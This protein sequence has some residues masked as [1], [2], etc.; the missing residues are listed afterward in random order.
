MNL[1]LRKPYKVIW[2]SI[3]IL[4]ILSLIG[5]G[6][7]LDIQMLDTYLVLAPSHVGISLSIIL[8]LIGL[9]YWL[10]KEKSLISWMTVS[11][12]IA[13]LL[14]FSIILLAG[15]SFNH[16]VEPDFGMFGVI[17]QLILILVFVSMV[18]QIVFLI[19]LIISAIR[20][21]E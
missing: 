5:I 14:T 4:L 12:V 18:S 7:T 3:P 6:S 19:N 15:L 9:L 21:G 11:H 16:L 8:A 17:N 20:N 13:T 2:L 1:I 10:V